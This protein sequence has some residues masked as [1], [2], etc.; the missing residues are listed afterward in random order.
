MGFFWRGGGQENIRFQESIPSLH[1][2]VLVK[3]K[4]TEVRQDIEDLGC[5]NL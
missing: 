1:K 4:Y 3:P 5:I 2:N